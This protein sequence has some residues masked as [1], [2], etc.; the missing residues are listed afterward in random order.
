MFQNKYILIRNLASLFIVCNMLYWIF[1]FPP[2]V[3]RVGLVLLSLYVIVFER[4]TKTSI[5][6]AVIAFA[7]FNLLHFFLSYLWITPSTTQ[8]GN[9]LC[10]LLPLSLFACLAEKGVMTEK[11]F[12]WIGAM[13]LVLSVIYFYHARVIYLEEHLFDADKSITNNASG[14]FLFMLPL[15]FLFRH[16]WQQWLTLVVC[17]F[18]LLQGAKRGN[19]VAA[20]IPIILFVIYSLKG[21]NKSFFKIFLVLAA[22]VVLGYFS[23]QWF[24]TN[25]YLMY[26]LEKTL[27]GD[28]SYRDLIYRAAW[29]TWFTSDSVIHYLFGYGFDGTINCPLMQGY[30]AHNDWFEILVDYGLVG[31]VL[32]LWIFIALF[33]Q[34]KSKSNLALRMV[35]LTVLFI[36]GLKTLFSMGF[37]EGS[38]SVLMISLGT[39]VGTKE[40]DNNKEYETHSLSC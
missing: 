13:L 9:I 6:K 20:A 36:W 21:G 4:R 5:E 15:C 14:I 8:I 40:F 37:T 31:A 10:A 28:S 27:E 26:R 16:K 30:R 7:C 38:M 12:S 25:D 11:F 23:Y 29:Q 24:I 1:P 2:V 32:Y 3:W 34:Y 35:I 17:V 39:V 22:F 18:F 19:I 33:K